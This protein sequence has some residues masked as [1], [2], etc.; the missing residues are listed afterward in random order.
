MFNVPYVTLRLGAHYQNKTKYICQ[1][2]CGRANDA[3]A[4]HAEPLRAG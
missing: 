3:G 1:V 2:L 4:S